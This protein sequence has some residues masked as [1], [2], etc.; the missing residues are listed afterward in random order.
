ML[1]DSWAA[2][3]VLLIRKAAFLGSVYFC[4][5]TKSLSRFTSHMP[6]SL[7]QA[8]GKALTMFSEEPCVR[9]VLRFWPVWAFMAPTAV[10]LGRVG[11][12][13]AGGLAGYQ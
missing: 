7:V 8:L 2:E 3:M 11:P 9:H 1:V 12:K 6:W 5:T 4:E 13:V 10:C